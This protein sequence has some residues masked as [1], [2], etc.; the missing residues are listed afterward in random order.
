MLKET[1][2]PNTDRVDNIIAY[3]SGQLTDI[4]T[5]EFFADLISSGIVWN[6]QG[7]YGRTAAHLIDGGYIDANG[8]ILKHLLVI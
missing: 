6:L 2:N 3:E 4:Q 8:T 5:I 1:Q 7:S